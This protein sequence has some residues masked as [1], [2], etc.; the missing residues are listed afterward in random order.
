MS[1]MSNGQSKAKFATDFK[2]MDSK[3]AEF[4]DNIEETL[5]NGDVDGFMVGNFGK[6][7]EKAVEKLKTFLENGGNVIIGSDDSWK[8]G[9]NRY[10]M[11]L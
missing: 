6:M 2:F 4:T 8:I 9:G 7:S 10:P 5:S 11:R 3:I 1:W